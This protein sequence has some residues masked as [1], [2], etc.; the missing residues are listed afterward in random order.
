[1]VG[2]I[3]KLPYKIF[4][5]SFKLMPRVAVDLL[6]IN[7]KGETLLTKRAKPPFAGYWH[8][9]GSFVFK[10]ERLFDC[11][12]RIA[13]DEININL[14]K[15]ELK[16]AGVFEDLKDDPRGHVIDIIYGYRLEDSD[17]ELKPVNE[18]KEMKFFKKLPLNIGFNHKEILK[19]LFL[20]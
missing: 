11:A 1:M 13:R 2:I 12:K 14:K 19:K 6:I 18:T 3:K 17:L 20:P 5:D 9:P 10:N 7:K 15:E 8:L 4:L 16:L